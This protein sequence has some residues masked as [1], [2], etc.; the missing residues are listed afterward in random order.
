MTSKSLKIRCCA[1]D[2]VLGQV[3]E[4]K[5]KTLEDNVVCVLRNEAEFCQQDKHTNKLNAIRF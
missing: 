3:L 5:K 1:F 4:K 2:Y